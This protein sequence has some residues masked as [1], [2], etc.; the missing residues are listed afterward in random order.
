MNSASLCSLAGRY[1][2]PIPPRFLAP[3]YFFKNSSSDNFVEAS[4]YEYLRFEVSVLISTIGKRPRGYGFLSGFPPFSFLVLNCRNC[5]RLRE[6]EEI[7]ISR[8]SLGL[9]PGCRPRIQT[10]DPLSFLSVFVFRGTF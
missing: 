4:E 3:I 10:Q 8:Q 7:E 2:N 5:K 9:L 1:D 6:F